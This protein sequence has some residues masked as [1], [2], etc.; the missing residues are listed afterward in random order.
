MILS[1]QAERVLSMMKR[2]VMCRLDGDDGMSILETAIVLPVLILLLLGAIDFGGAYYVAIEVNSAA[3]AAAVYGAQNFTDTTG[4]V[5]AATS[6][7]SDL[8]TLSTTAT[9]GCECSDGSSSVASCTTTPTCTHN[10][11]YY[12]QVNTTATYNSV[13]NYPGIPGTLSF[14]GQARM[15]AAY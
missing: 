13:F 6:D 7:A 15:R 12:V 9:Y 10:V 14:S 1:R 4:M 8:S 5:T 11:V 2:R 3:H